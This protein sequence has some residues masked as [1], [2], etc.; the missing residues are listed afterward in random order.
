MKAYLVTKNEELPD[1]SGLHVIKIPFADE[2]TL[3][4]FDA[5]LGYLEIKGREKIM[6]FI[7][8]LKN[9]PQTSL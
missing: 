7:H 8:R 9:E 2:D 3:Y 6:E 1:I 5:R 4:V